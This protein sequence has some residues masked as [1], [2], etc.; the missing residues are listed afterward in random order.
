MYFYTLE[1]H[2]E[3]EDGG[4]PGHPDFWYGLYVLPDFLALQVE[5][6]WQQFHSLMMHGNDAY[7]STSGRRFVVDVGLPMYV[8]MEK[9]NTVEAFAVT[10]HDRN[11]IHDK[12]MIYLLGGKDVYKPSGEEIAFINHPEYLAA[13]KLTKRAQGLVVSDK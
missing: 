4:F 8:N 6:G 10:P 3:P 5:A 12:M 11:V 9:E 2:N 7:H 13:F 1:E